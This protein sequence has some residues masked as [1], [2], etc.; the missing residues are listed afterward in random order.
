MN[1]KRITHFMLKAIIMMVA[2][3]APVLSF[4]DGPVTLLPDDQDNQSKDGDGKP[5]NRAPMRVLTIDAMYAEG[6]LSCS[7]WSN[8]DGIVT[9]T[10]TDQAGATLFQASCTGRQLADGV[11]IGQFDSFII[12]LTTASGSAYTGE[13]AD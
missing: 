8:A 4:A 10:V 9:L 2:A 3:C 1:A 13:Y 12:A 11:T 5:K 7:E 6:V